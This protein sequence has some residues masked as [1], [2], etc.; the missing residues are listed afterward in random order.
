[1]RPLL[2]EGAVRHQVQDREV[3]DHERQLEREAKADLQQH[4]DVEVVLGARHDGADLKG[5]VEEPPKG[6]GLH[7]EEAEEHT[8]EEE[9]HH[10]RHRGDDPLALAWA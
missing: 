9:E 1:M 10:R 5:L 2:A 4:V 3:E 6:G 8:Q 7:H